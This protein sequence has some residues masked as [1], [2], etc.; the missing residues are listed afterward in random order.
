MPV[1][2][3]GDRAVAGQGPTHVDQQV[4]EDHVLTPGGLSRSLYMWANNPC[5][6]ASAPARSRIEVTESLCSG[7]LTATH[8]P[9]RSISVAFPSW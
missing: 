7:T 3:Q 5:V 2:D 1:D 8:D 4:I 6:N 9:P